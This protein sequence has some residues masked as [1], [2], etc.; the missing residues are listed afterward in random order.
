MNLVGHAAVAVRIRP[1]ASDELLVGTMAPDLAGMARV[2]LSPVPAHDAPRV[3]VAIGVALHHASDASFHGSR[4]FNDH[5]QALRDALLDAGVDRGAARACAHAGLE[6]LLDGELMRDPAIAEGA[7]R[8]LAALTVDGAV[9]DAVVVLA[10]AD[11]RERWRER[12]GMIGHNLD[13]HG[14]RSPDGVA[15]RLQRVT[16][17]RARIALRAAQ[18]ATVAQVLR[19]YQPFL[20]ADGARVVDGVVAD[21]RGP[22]RSARLQKA[23]TP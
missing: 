16:S 2:R 9:L 10:P 12:L 20:V 13:P 22:S 18:V 21:V 11:A 3:D 14:Y 5:T 17:G 4:W 8:A 1:E 19:T 6:M 15:A 7:N 23:A